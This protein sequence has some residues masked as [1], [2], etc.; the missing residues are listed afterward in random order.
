MVHYTQMMTEAYGLLV[1]KV[2][3]TAS[4]ENAD[5]IVM[6]N[7]GETLMKGQA[8]KSSSA[9]ICPLFSN[10]NLSGDTSVGDSFSMA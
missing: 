1:F 4:Q 9:T 5:K 6:E 2:I 3:G 10:C 8:L 7:L